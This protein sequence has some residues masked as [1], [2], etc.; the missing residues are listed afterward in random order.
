[1]ALEGTKLSNMGLRDKYELIIAYSRRAGDSDDS[2]FD[3]RRESSD[4]HQV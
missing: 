1:M 3:R 2:R 4:S